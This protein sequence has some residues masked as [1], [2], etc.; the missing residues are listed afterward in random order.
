MAD[1]IVDLVE[2]TS[3]PRQLLVGSSHA[4]LLLMFHALTE[5]QYRLQWEAKGH[6][7]SRAKP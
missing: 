2:E 5:S 3:R 1:S 7:I 4:Q 6:G